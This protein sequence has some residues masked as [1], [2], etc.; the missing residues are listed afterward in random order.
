[1]LLHRQLVACSPLLSLLCVLLASLATALRHTL[2]AALLWLGL[3]RVALAQ[4]M[5]KT[6][7]VSFGSEQ[8]AP[9]NARLKELESELARRRVALISHHDARDRFTA[10]S[11]TPQT[12][13]ELDIDAL[14]KE[15]QQAIQHVALGQTAGAQRSVR[16]IIDLADRSLETLNR[17]TATARTLLDACLALVR[18]SLHENKRDAAI[19][20]AMRCRRLVPDLAPSEV[21][22]PANVVGALA[23]ADDQLRR[24]RV[25]NLSVHAVPER[26]CDVYLNGRHLGHTPFTLDRAP[27]G[28]YRVQVECAGEKTARVHVVQLGDEPVQ[29]SIDAAFDDAVLA[30]PRLSLRYT[31]DE[32]ARASLLQHAILLGREV[33]AED[34]VLQGS[35]GG[36]PLLLR[37]QVRHGRLVAGSAGAIEGAPALAGAVDA[38]TQTRFVGVSRELL[39]PR[40]EASAAAGAE[41]AARG[42]AQAAQAPEPPAPVPTASA[43]AAATPEPS[44]PASRRGLR[45]GGGIL[46]GTGAATLAAGFGLQVRAGNLRDDAEA[47]PLGSDLQRSKQQ[48]YDDFRYVPLIGVVGSGLMTAAVPLLLRPEGPRSPAA[49]VGGA[50]A[51][52]AGIAALVLGAVKTADEPVLGTLVLSS[53]SPLLTIPITQLVRASR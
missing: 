32:Q 15:A 11:R 38:L 2:L 1:M 52:A 31:S 5:G 16:R 35:L 19:D 49:W 9:N 3:S 18:S 37:V 48:K 29:I 41:P 47:E 26:G 33:R 13:S 27:V 12:P 6:V 21:A 53:A 40:P 44:A 34:V 20:Q 45:I 17:E 36:Q 4:P 51:G 30:E 22:H 23:E 8:S 28:E 42:P 50:L 14:A 39:A 25:G 46:L 43:A 10:R 24:M 7:V